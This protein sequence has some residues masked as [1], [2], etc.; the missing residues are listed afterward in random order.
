MYLKKSLIRVFALVILLGAWACTKPIKQNY[1]NKFKKIGLI[2]FMPNKV[3]AVEVKNLVNIVNSSYPLA[4][5]NIRDDY[6]RELHRSIK[7]HTDLPIIPYDPRLVEKTG[8][9]AIYPPNLLFNYNAGRIDFEAYKKLTGCDA[10]F[11]STYMP[12][13]NYGDSG[14]EL[15]GYGFIFSPRSNNSYLDDNL[16]L[17]DLEEKKVV[18]EHESFYWENTDEAAGQGDY[19]TFTD[20][21]KDNLGPLKKA[22]TAM[23]K[24]AAADHVKAMGKGIKTS[25]YKKEKK[26]SKTI[27]DLIE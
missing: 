7:E 6:A 27:F 4:G 14:Y 21:E 24:Y 8:M 22:L 26:E 9:D 25:P 16:Y 17:Y 15:N 10:V 2:S 19:S 13:N 12:R 5:I 23:Y 20:L 11:I 3:H 1:V 18:W